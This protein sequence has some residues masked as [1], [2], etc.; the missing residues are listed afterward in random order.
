MLFTAAAAVAILF[1]KQ[2]VGWFMFINSAMV[3]FLLPLS[4]FRF[5]WWRFN[6][7]GEL[8]A[9]ALGLPLSI[10]VWFVLDFQNRHPMWQGLGLLFALSFVVLLAVTLLTP[11]E[12]PETLEQ[13]YRRCRP[14][15]FWGAIR[16]RLAGE[17]PA[18]P[19]VGRLVA[20]SALG[21]LACLGLVV[22]TNALFVADWPTTAAGAA[23]PFWAGRGSSAA[24][25]KSKRGAYD[26]SPGNSWRPAGAGKTVPGLA[27][28][29]GGGGAAPGGGP[30]E[31]KLG[32]A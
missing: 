5:F 12:S 7:W 29:W 2:M 18:G 8:A 30:A 21:I 1:V 24:S 19:S 4:F 28:L 15:G 27:G 6:A 13:F 16:R 10:V 23:P 9:I 17:V 25:C 32:P 20:N 3:I 11:A 26:G 22:A 14:P 31:R